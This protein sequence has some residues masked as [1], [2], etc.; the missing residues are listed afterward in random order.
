MIAGVEIGI[1]V[2]VGNG[3]GVGIEVET[4]IEIGIGVVCPVLVR[5]HLL[6]LR[7]QTGPIEL[8]LLARW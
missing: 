1:E 3:I 7:A 2:G 5:L 8:M 6:V 4:R